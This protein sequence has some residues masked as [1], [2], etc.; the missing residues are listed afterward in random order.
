MFLH[1][2]SFCINSL[3]LIEEI[4]KMNNEKM[5]ENSL[6]E[7]I[8]KLKRNKKNYC[9]YV[10]LENCFIGSDV[11]KYGNMLSSKHGLKIHGKKVYFYIIC[12]FYYVVSF[13]KNHNKLIPTHT[14][15]N[16]KITY[17]KHQL[18]NIYKNMKK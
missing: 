10:Y 7:A 11:I 9:D 16:N 8:C 5:F 17:T 1:N 13:I 3:N 2:N 14:I 15:K 6:I 18:L 12:N 4:Q